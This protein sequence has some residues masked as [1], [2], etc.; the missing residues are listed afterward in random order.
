MRIVL[1]IV[2]YLAF[3]KAYAQE[4]HAWIYFTDKPNVTASIASPQSILTQKAIQRKA[5]HGIAIDD[6]DVPVNQNYVTQIQSQPGITYKTQSKW[7]N[8]VH[9]TGL[10]TDINAL[11]ALSFVSSID[12]ADPTKMTQIN[13]HNKFAQTTIPPLTY[14]NALNQIDMIGLNDLHDLGNTGSGVTIAVTDSGF[15]NVDTNPAFQQLRN[16]NG[17]AGGYDFVAGDNS[18]YGD[19]FH[20]ARVLSIMAAHEAGNFEGSAPDAQYYLFRTEDVATETPVELSYWVAAAERAD[21]LGVDVI[22]VSLGYLSFDNPAESLSYTDL[23]G[24]TAF[25]SR[26]ANVAFEKGLFVVVSAGNSGTSTSHPYI[27]A[28]A[29]AAGA[30]S[31]GSVT[32]TEQLSNFSSTGP[33]FD[34][35]LKPNVVAQGS[36]TALITENGALVSGSGTS[37]SAP[38]ISG[39]V[40]CLIQA[41]PNLTPLQLKNAIEQSADNF[42]TPNNQFGYGIP[43]FGAVFQTLSITQFK[44]VELNYYINNSKQLVVDLPQDYTE[45]Q[46][47]LYNL[48]GQCVWT[49][50]LE[51]E[52]P[53][54]LNS[55]NSGI[56]IFQI[57]ELNRSINVAF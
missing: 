3:G 26:G 38:L 43:D 32:A 12:F 20:G 1:C 11:F 18:Y 5:R 31:I 33:T 47:R 39:A 56:Y 44:D 36:G 42:M 34:N 45:V 4:L 14:G 46:A 6:R 21:S 50:M 41:Y 17:V 29:D 53:L 19:H 37:Y 51:N 16:N 35:R 30:F 55:F 2:F 40:A 54:E 13:H 48:M 49:G 52:K 22:N 15:P 24:Q 9:V 25:I 8:C 7:F 28:P 57:E 27:S 23:D 10:E